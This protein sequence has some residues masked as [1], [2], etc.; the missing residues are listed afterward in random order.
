MAGGK[1]ISSTLGIAGFPNGETFRIGNPEPTVY[2][3]R[4]FLRQHISLDKDH[5]EEISDDVNQVKERVSTSRITLPA[6]KFSLV[7]FFNN[8]TISHHPRSHFINLP[9][10]NTCT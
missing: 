2:I 9:L 3:G 7:H 5:Y 8:N 4:I 1:G 10:I 6:G